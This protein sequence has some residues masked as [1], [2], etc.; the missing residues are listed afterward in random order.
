MEKLSDPGSTCHWNRSKTNAKKILEILT[1][2]N[3]ISPF[4]KLHK[5]LKIY[6]YIIMIRLTWN[7]LQPE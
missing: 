4:K 1:N 2:D 5:T 7:L 3:F 6:L